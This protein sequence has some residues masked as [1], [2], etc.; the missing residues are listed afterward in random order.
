MAGDAVYRRKY[1][2]SKIIAFQSLSA[3]ISFDQNLTILP[4][5]SNFI[6]FLQVGAY[7]A[8]WGYGTGAAGTAWHFIPVAVFDLKGPFNGQNQIFYAGQEVLPSNVFTGHLLEDDDEI[9]FISQ[10]STCGT[11][12]GHADIAQTKRLPSD[13][14]S[15]ARTNG[16]FKVKDCSTTGCTIDVT[17]LDTPFGGYWKICY[18][19]KSAGCDGT[20]AK[21][22]IEAGQLNVKG[23][24]MNQLRDCISYR[25]CSWSEILG[26]GRTTDW[27]FAFAELADLC[28]NEATDATTTGTTILQ[29]FDPAGGPIHPWLYAD[30]IAINSDYTVSI[31]S[32]RLKIGGEF[33][34]CVCTQLPCD[35]SWDFAAHA[36]TVEIVGPLTQVTECILGENCITTLIGFGLKDTNRILISDHTQAECFGNAQVPT[37]IDQHL[38][39]PSEGFQNWQ[40]SASGGFCVNYVFG[41]LNFQSLISIRKFLKIQMTD[42]KILFFPKPS[43][44]VPTPGLKIPERPSPSFSRLLTRP[45]R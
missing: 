9:I 33:K 32:Q 5:Y 6:S 14:A 17:R 10:H 11:E 1:F 29:K 25:D 12:V 7:H 24:N 41:I 28:G 34:I 8:C 42:L 15:A 3:K 36:G 44:P 37:N 16:V 2:F 43:P 13:S 26:S 23:P 39:N 45:R 30:P 35:S 18:C 31:A 20:A 21:Y 19:V 40:L 38:T 22:P 27:R 4:N